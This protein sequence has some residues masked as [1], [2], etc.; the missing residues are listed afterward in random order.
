M[1]GTQ[2]GFSFDTSSCSGCLARML[3]CF[4]RNDV[5]GTEF[6]VIASAVRPSMVIIPR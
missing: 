5:P 4:D 2:L 1:T 3:A 6:A